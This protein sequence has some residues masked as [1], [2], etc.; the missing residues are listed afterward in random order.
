MRKV[1][2]TVIAFL[3]LGAF[4]LGMTHISPRRQD[5]ARLVAPVLVP[6]G[7]LLHLAG[8]ETR[9]S[10]PLAEEVSDLARTLDLDAATEA[11]VLG[12]TRQSFYS[13]VASVRGLEED[14]VPPLIKKRTDELHERIAS[15]L[16]P[17]RAARYRDLVR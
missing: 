16:D 2:L 12:L 3:S 14:A 6:P 8:E 5:P 11:K 15:L 10:D 9:F 17:A 1:E 4:G 13:V 7:G